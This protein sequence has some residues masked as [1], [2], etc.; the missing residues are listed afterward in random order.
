MGQETQA[1]LS[2]KGCRLAD[3][4]HCVGVKKYAKETRGD[5]GYNLAAIVSV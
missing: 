2:V 4:N 3:D 1:V 5:R